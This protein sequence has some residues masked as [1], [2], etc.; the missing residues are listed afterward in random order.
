MIR[1]GLY[2]K[3]AGKKGRGVFTANPIAEN[4]VLEISPV[5]VLKAKDR[6]VCEDTLLYYYIFEWG[7]KG[8][9]GAIGLGYISIYNHASPSNCEYTMDF[10]EQTITITAMRDI[11]AG[12]ELTINY[13]AGWDDWKP[14]WFEEEN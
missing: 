8:K 11:A 3:D 7:N 10:G 14:V 1:N 12:E 9:K 13:S 2:I 5:L 4:T 6:Q